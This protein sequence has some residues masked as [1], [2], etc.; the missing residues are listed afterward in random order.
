[1]GVPDKIIQ[2]IMRHEDVKTTIKSYIKP[3]SDDVK[4]AMNDLAQRWQADEKRDVP[5]PTVQ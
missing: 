1:M 2:R 3:V 5:A 4:Q